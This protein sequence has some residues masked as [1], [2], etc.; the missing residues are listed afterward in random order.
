MPQVPVHYSGGPAFGQ[1]DSSAFA[2]SGN[3]Q[4]TSRVLDGSA[5]HGFAEEWA[6]PGTVVIDGETLRA[7][8]IYLFEAEE[9]TEDADNYPWDDAHVARVIVLD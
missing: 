5:D 8:R 3:A 4:P 9:V 6:E 1:V 2:P 7:S